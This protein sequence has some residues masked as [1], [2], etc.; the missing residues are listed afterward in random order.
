MKAVDVRNEINNV[1]AVIH[2]DAC[3]RTFTDKHICTSTR[4]G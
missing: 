4:S 1:I 3:T 2:T